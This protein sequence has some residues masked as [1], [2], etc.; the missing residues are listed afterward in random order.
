[1]EVDQ[2][3]ANLEG[4]A[5]GERAGGTGV[6]SARWW[7]GSYLGIPKQLCCRRR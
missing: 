5:V 3:K 6:R 1:V 4:S 2:G 7:Y